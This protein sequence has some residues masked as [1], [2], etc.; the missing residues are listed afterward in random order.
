MLRSRLNSFVKTERQKLVGDKAEI[1][2]ENGERLSAQNSDEVFSYGA[3][4]NYWGV[5][6]VKAN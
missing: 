1:S 4:K 3:M 6:H 2:F 5:S